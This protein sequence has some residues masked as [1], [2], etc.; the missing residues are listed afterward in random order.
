MPCFSASRSPVLLSRWGRPCDVPLDPWPSYAVT[1]IAA[2][3][4]RL[5][6]TFRDPRGP[7]LD[8]SYGG[9]FSALYVL[10][11]YQ[12]RG[13]GERLLVAYGWAHLTELKRAGLDE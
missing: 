6:D 11:A 9:E 7:G 2:S 5:S 10:K 4:R 13:I 12:R 3:R 8:G 1:A